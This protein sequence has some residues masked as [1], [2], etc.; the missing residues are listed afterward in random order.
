MQIAHETF[1]SA[2]GPELQK[3]PGQL[4]NVVK[5]PAYTSSILTMAQ[6]MLDWKIR[7]AD[8]TLTGY[9]ASPAGL[10]SRP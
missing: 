4:V 3:D 8:K 6:K 9:A 5:D 10:T 2:E 1:P 7:F